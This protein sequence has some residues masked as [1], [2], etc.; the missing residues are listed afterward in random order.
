MHDHDSAIARA[1]DA[2]STL[3]K[4][5]HTVNPTATRELI[6]AAR[7]EL[8]Q[9]RSDK[10]GSSDA[11]DGDHEAEQPVHTARRVNQHS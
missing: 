2:F 11:P 5:R 8:N 3:V 7:A 9:I 1:L 10:V 6:A 4:S